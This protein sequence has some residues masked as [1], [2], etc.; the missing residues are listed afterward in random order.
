M[1]KMIF[2]SISL[3]LLVFSSSSYAVRGGSLVKNWS[4][5]SYVVSLDE[6]KCTG[7]V[8]AASWVL[9]AGHCRDISTVKYGSLD[10]KN[11]PYQVS[12][13]AY[14]IDPRF[15]IHDIL[16]TTHYDFQLLHLSKPIDLV[17]TGIVPIKLADPSF[18]ANLAIG[19]LVRVRGWSAGA[20]P[21]PMLTEALLPFANMKDVSE[22]DLHKYPGPIGPFDASHMAIGVE[23]G[24]V[25]ICS[26]D[27]GGPLT[28]YDAQSQ[29]EVQ[30]GLATSGGC[31]RG[32]DG[33][34]HEWYSVSASLAVAYDSIVAIMSR[35]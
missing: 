35:H 12:V 24:N 13:D 33:K 2:G 5:A 7:S 3:A 28:V 9:T 30:I 21:R 6:Q 25:G 29:Q 15:V 20:A 1:G 23:D 11:E 4:E 27:S 14:W 10:A 19:T 8:I 17:K 26:G 32:E 22:S 18:I 31:H 16:H 34:I